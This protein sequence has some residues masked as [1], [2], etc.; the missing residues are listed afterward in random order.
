MT[1]LETTDRTFGGDA[2][3]G[4][5]TIVCPGC[6]CENTHIAEVFTRKGTDPYGARIYEG[7]V[8]K[9]DTPYS[10]ASQCAGHR[11]RL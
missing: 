8:Q 6:G 5:R 11:V 3:F 7:T 2:Y 10:L 9:R 1:S 4:E